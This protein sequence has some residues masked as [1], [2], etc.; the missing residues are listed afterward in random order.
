L[1]DAL[2]LVVGKLLQLLVL[3]EW[4]VGGAEAGVGSGVD[5]LLLAVFEELRSTTR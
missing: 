3:V 5:A 4:R 1:L 2:A